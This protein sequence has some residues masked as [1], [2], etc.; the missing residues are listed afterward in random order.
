MIDPDS[1]LNT[2]QLPDERIGD[3]LEHDGEGLGRRVGGD[4]DDR[5]PGFDRDGSIGGRRADLADEVGQ[6]VDA[7]ERGR[8]TEQDRELDV[9]EHL[10]GQRALQLRDRRDVTGEVALELLVVAGDDLLD[11]RVVQRVLLGLDLGRQRRGVV[12]AAGL[13]LEGLVRQDVGDAVER[14]FLAEREL[15]RHDAAAEGGA[16]LLE[17]TVEV[18]PLL[19]LLV[20]E[21]HAGHAQLG[22]APPQHL[23]LDLDPL[24][25][26]HHEDGQVGDRQRRLHLR[27]EVGVAGG[28]DDVDAIGAVAVLPLERRECQRERDLP[29]HRFGL[30]VGGGRPVVH[31]ARPGDGSRACQQRLDQRGLPAPAVSEQYDVADLVRPRIVHLAPC[32]RSGT[33][34]RM[35]AVA[36]VP[37]DRR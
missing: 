26:A 17:H 25:G 15:Q 7:D 8:R 3:R 19:V 21:D 22:A 1:T 29:L 23:G 20:D 9:V 11:E 6:P 13:V 32:I 33:P 34:W 16:E 14:R 10:V 37:C 2:R 24:D 12:R 18:G 28:V 36:R 27:H 35:V 4:L 30:G 5:V 31:L